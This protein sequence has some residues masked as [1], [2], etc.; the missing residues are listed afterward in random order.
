MLLSE[1][2]TKVRYLRPHA[3]EMSSYDCLDRGTGVTTSLRWRNVS[4]ANLTPIPLVGAR[5][6]SRSAKA[7]ALGVAVL[8]V[9]GGVLYAHRV[10]ASRRAAHEAAELAG[11]VARGDRVLH[12][13]RSGGAISLDGDTDDRGWV[14][15]PGAATTRAFLTDDGNP[16]RPY[17]Q[18]RIVWGGDY[19]YLALFAS[20]EDIESRVDRPDAPVGPDDDAFH[21]VFSRD[22]TEYAFDVSP[23]AMITDAR[24]V[25][26][27][28]WD[29]TWNSE[30]RGSKELGGSINNP[31]GLDEEWEVEL[32][33]P[34]ESLGLTGEPGE[35]IGAS[36]RRCDKPKESS[37][38]CA[39]WGDGPD[40]RVRGRLVLD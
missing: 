27:G 15:P 7:I 8:V 11:S 38:V 13:P 1:D 19:L 21:V 25:G 31:N 10:R 12:L 9:G 24:R 4:D 37:R 20:D 30:A 35:N 16:A 22:D 39:G 36:F 17:S 14:G 23:N 6:I 28:A 26:T 40:G 32:A 34:L 18:A 2:R 5:M 33:I 3:V 29:T